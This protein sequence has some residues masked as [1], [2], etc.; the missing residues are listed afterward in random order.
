MRKGR[1]A[2]P[3]K[4]GRQAVAPISAQTARHIRSTLRRALA[5]AQRADLV[6]RNVAAMAAPPYQ[7]H[8]PI[9]YLSAADV[10]RL[11]DVTA[12]DELGPLYA[13]AVTTG[14][15]Q[16]ELLGL[17]WDNVDLPAGTLTVAH[18]LALDAA[19]GF[20]LAEPK[21]ARSR[22]TIPLPAVA[23]EALDRQLARQTAARLAAGTTWQDRT[24]YVFTDSVGRPLAPSAVSLAWRRARTA[25]GLPPVRFHDL[26]HTAATML[27]AEGVPLIVISDLL[28]HAGIAITAASYAGIVPELR[29]DAAAAMDRA[30]GRQP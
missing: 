16:G 29:R 24:G 19:G 26:R 9:A 17:T 5:D 22:R 11:L 30:T 1:P 14:L 21:S 6:V 8:R 7:A 20:T 15:R 4:R 12:E 28:G 2:T 27:L 10:G 13:L 25:A 18:A 3:S 23:R